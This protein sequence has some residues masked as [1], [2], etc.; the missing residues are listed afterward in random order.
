MKNIVN[1]FQYVFQMMG[2]YLQGVGTFLLN[3]V[4]VNQIK[5]EGL[6]RKVILQEAAKAVKYS[7]Q[8]VR[9]RVNVSK[10]VKKKQTKLF[11][12]IHDRVLL[13]EKLPTLTDKNFKQRITDVVDIAKGLIDYP[14][15]SE[16]TLAL[17][18]SVFYPGINMA[19]VE[20][21][22]SFDD[23]RFPL[24]GEEKTLAMLQKEHQERLQSLSNK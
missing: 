9:K 18:G 17:I 4:N 3:W 24:L 23:I 22:L 10:T 8:V 2:R 12:F 5:Q 19:M 21:E 1:L 20:K 6:D 11:Q 14:S 13:D 7:L 15:V 16:A